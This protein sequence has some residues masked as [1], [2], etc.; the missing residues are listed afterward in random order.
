[1]TVA[2]LSTSK[3]F[4]CLFSV[5][6]LEKI[7][8]KYFEGYGIGNMNINLMYSSDLCIQLK[9]QCCLKL[10]ISMGEEHFLKYLTRIHIVYFIRILKFII[11]MYTI[12]IL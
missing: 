8:R 5:N 11:K 12:S 6:I 3:S 7:H 1:M 10:V 9:I 2:S 4:L